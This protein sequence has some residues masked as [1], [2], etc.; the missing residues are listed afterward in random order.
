M[1]VCV[2]VFVCVCVYG[3]SPQQPDVLKSH[4]Y[5]HIRTYIMFGSTRY[6]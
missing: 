2:C 3:V 6:R 4:I 5:T 1:C